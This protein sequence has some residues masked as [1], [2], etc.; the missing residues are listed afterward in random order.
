MMQFLDFIFYRTYTAYLN[1]GESDVPGIYALA[2][3]T[4]FPILNLLSFIFIYITF[5]NELDWNIIKLVI[6]GL[7]LLLLT[8]H[9]YRIY[10]RV[11]LNK[12]LSNWKTTDTHKK[13]RLSILMF[14]YIVL[15][16]VILF[17]TVLI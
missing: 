3:I 7:F 6:V 8:V 9:Y 17:M 5:I 1:W 11:G 10:K 2:V 16:M 4:L 13:K 12:L 14:F 15:T